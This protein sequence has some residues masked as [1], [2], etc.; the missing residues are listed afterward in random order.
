MKY[1]KKPIEVE[2]FRLGFDEVPEWFT[3]HT[4]L[5]YFNQIEGQ[6]FC[7]IRTLDDKINGAASTGDYIIKGIHGEMYPCKADVF[8]S[9]YELVKEEGE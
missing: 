3:N 8:E 6:V 2:A 7:T 1:I 9:S 4:D 5:I